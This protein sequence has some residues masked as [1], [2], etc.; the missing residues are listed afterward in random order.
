MT[1]MPIVTMLAVAILLAG[2][3]ETER[4]PTPGPGSSTID[5]KVEL[6]AAIEQR[7]ENPQAHYELGKIYR[8][9]GLW[10]Q[11]R[12]HFDVVTRIAPTHWPARAA[13]VRLLTDRNRSAEADATVKR[14]VGQTA[15]PGQLTRL[16][17]AF[18]AEGL[19]D[20]ALQAMQE[21]LKRWPKSALVL[22]QLGFYYL[23]KND[24]KQ[25]E[26]YLRESFA[27]DP[28]QPDVAYEL[29]KLGVVIE[30]PKP[31][32]PPTKPTESSASGAAASGTK[33]PADQPDS[34]TTTRPERIP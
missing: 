6:R 13:L 14:F 10:D 26:R 32:T 18:R 27:I 11:A 21:G 17:E 22:R 31:K 3:T 9:E 24:T 12:F 4:T 16:I 20:A 15:D 34:S 23:A 1:R 2:C 28:H 19:D 29:G 7:F 25:A 5:R 8:N 30:S 33:A